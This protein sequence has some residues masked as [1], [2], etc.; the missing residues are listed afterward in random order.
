[1]SLSLD[2]EDCGSALC[3]GAWVEYSTDGITWDT[4]GAY[5]QGT[6]WYNKD[7]ASGKELWSVQDYTRWH[8][9]TIPLPTNI[10]NLRLRIVM[11]SD[12]G[13]SKEGIGVD[14]IHIYDNT[15]GI[16]TTTGTSPVVNQPVVNGTGWIDFVE[17]GSQRLIASIKPDGQDLGSTDVQSY[18]HT[19]AVRFEI[20]ATT[21]QYYHNR[22]ITIK[23]TTVN[24]PDSATVRFYFTDAETEALINAT[25]C[26]TCY[27]PTTAYDLG[28]TKYSD[29]LDNFENGTLDDNTQGTHSF[30]NSA[31]V[32]KVPFDRGY[33]AQFRVKDFSEFWLNNGGFDN[34]TSLPVELISFT[35]KKKN[36]KDVMVE[37]ITATE[38][39]VDRFE[40]EV[41][42]GISAFQQTRFERIGMVR[43]QGNSNQQQSY[44]FMDIENG[45]TGVRYYRLKII[46]ADGSYTYSAVRPVQF[47]DE[48]QW[49]G[50]SQSFF[51]NF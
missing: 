15:Y 30:I 12:A 50:I 16:Y 35:A 41:A 29:P 39:H 14:D 37:W 33:Y 48:V 11:S 7:F 2:L 6:N 36:I 46:E 4:L 45:K 13:V 34:N 27:K 21:S 22:N 9:A 19:G 17:T 3:D 25:G 18:V 47:N 40:I 8:V 28:V 32:R 43:S 38:Q 51:R 23:P 49:T 31:K 26:G 24:L 44:E 20:G 5:G 10:S 1:M 42:K